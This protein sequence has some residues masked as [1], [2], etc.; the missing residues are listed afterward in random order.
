MASDL[1][2]IQRDK[3][4]ILSIIKYVL[5]V[6]IVLLVLFLGTKLFSLLIPVILGFILASASNTFSAMIFRLVRR[7]KPRAKEEGGDSKG[8]RIFKLINFTLLL[9]LFIGFLIFIIF[10]L[11]SQVRNL[12]DFVNTSVPTI[13]I[14]TNLSAWLN[15]ISNDLGGILPESTITMISTELT[16]IQSDILS[17]LP[18]L[19]SS[20]L[21]SILAFI[22]NIPGLLFQAIVIVMSGYY[23][24]TDRIVIGKFIREILPSEAFVSKVTGVV[25]KVSNSLFRV[26]GGYAII[27]SVTFIEA[28]IG[29]SIMRIP[30]TVIVALIVMFVDLLPAVGASA[31]F[32]PIAIYMF[33]QGRIFEGVVSLI[34]VVVMTLVR[35][36]LEPRVIGTAM[37]LHPLATLIAMILGVAV[38]GVPGF[39]AGPILLVIII[40]IMDSFGFKQ[41]AREW[42][43]KI[44]NKVATADIKPTDEIVPGSA[45]VKHIVV[46]QFKDEAMGQLREKNM[47][48]VKE[49]LLSL[50]DVIPEILSM[51]VGID[52]KFESNAYDCVLIASFASYE[53]LAKYKIHPAHKK[54]AKWIEQVVTSKTVIDFDI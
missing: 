53:D 40:G 16:A 30:Y 24:I 20:A 9:L 11:I 25:Y 14:V 32:Y 48:D 28:L 10:A 33:I 45:K 3:K 47:L 44:L 41:I 52:T 13:E 2:K 39:L 21:N 4:L 18:K 46:W 23:F 34:I 37:K 36:A 15:G 17:A 29:L 1:D 35:T 6:A 7:K 31:C 27:M 38:F 22:G 8:Y 54:V 5:V 49:K 42:L 50:A 19:T 51:Q 12:L 26:L 43:G